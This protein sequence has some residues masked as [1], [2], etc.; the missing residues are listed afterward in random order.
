MIFEARNFGSSLSD[1]KLSPLS[2]KK[3]KGIKV[4]RSDEKMKAWGQPTK[5]EARVARLSVLGKAPK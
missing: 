4:L 3:H 5:A 1:L 2:P